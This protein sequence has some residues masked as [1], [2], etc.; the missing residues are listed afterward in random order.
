MMIHISPTLFSLA[1]VRQFAP[2]L[3]SLG[4]PW[5][6]RKLVEWTPIKSV[7]K[8][9]HMSDVMH[10]AAQDI[11]KQKRHDLSLGADNVEMG[12]S[13]LKDITSLLRKVLWSRGLS[14]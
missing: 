2:F 9:K 4:P 6:R 13:Q 8:V 11:L 1:L 5:F 7:Q 3:V 14:H 12:D 10:K